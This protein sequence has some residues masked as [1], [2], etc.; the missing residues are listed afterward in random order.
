MLTK[1]KTDKMSFKSNR[2]YSR[3]ENLQNYVDTNEARTKASF[4]SGGFNDGTPWWQKESYLKAIG[5]GTG[6]ME[7]PV[8]KQVWAN[9]MGDNIVGAYESWQLPDNLRYDNRYVSDKDKQ[10]MEYFKFQNKK[11]YQDQQQQLQTYGTA[12]QPVISNETMNTNNTDNNQQFGMANNAMAQQPQGN[13]FSM[14]AINAASNIYGNLAERT[15]S[16]NTPSPIALKTNIDPSK[17]YSAVDQLKNTMSLGESDMSGRTN[18]MKDTG[19]AGSSL[20]LPGLPTRN[21]GGSASGGSYSNPKGTSSTSPG[22]NVNINTGGNDNNNNSGYSFLDKNID[23]KVTNPY[24]DPFWGTFK[25]DKQTFANRIQDAKDK[26]QLNK[27]ARITRRRDNWQDR[28][29]G[30]GTGVGNFLRSINIFKGKN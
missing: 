3:N 13:T 28:Q 8:E 19:R 9:G 21:T 22:T 2:L 17:I 11:R 1:T 15:A 25:R 5:K 18:Y 23:I 10:G 12:G 24:K 29:T 6:D 26:G 27:A 14:G 4:E 7:K 20:S 30:K 16:V